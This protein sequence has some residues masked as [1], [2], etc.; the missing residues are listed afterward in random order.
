[1]ASAIAQLQSD[2]L[3]RDFPL[4]DLLRRAYVIARKLGLGD[5]ERWIS[6]EMNGYTRPQNELPEYRMASGEVKAWNPYHGWVPVIF[7]SPA[8]AAIVSKRGIGGSVAE[9][10][11]LLGGSRD[12]QLQMPLPQGAQRKLSA[13]MGYDTNFT[14]FVS[15]QAVVRVLDA[16]R[17]AV[18][19]WALRLE[20]EGVLGEGLTFSTQ[21]K[22]AAAQGAH[23][24][25]NFFGPVGEA[26][27]LQP[28]GD[29]V[30]VSTTIDLDA[31]RDVVTAIRE[32][33]HAVALTEET[34]CEVTAELATVDAQLSSPNPKRGIVKESLSSLRSIL[35]GAGGGV[36][37]Q[38]AIELGKILIGG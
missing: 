7:E 12:G 35:E 1:M 20:E 38:L 11:D 17:S 6:E 36:A 21:E 19:Q 28:G 25:N 34:A 2:A 29:A 4:T 22:E 24:V 15:R 8:E 33:L 31:V 10:E 30:M 26:Q 18:L 23:N 37:G 27:L 16:V 3:D 5:F 32:N 14:L 13:S 9:L